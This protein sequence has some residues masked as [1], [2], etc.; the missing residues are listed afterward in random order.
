MNDR[1]LDTINKNTQELIDLAISI[2]NYSEIGF[3]E[4]QS[5]KVLINYLEKEGFS[6]KTPLAE[7]ETA[8]LAKYG[9]GRP[10][11]AL[12]AEYDALP[13]IGHAC[14]HN[15]IGVM[16]A[17]AAVALVQ[18]NLFKQYPGTVSVVGC[19]AEECGNV[20][21]KMVKAGI[22]NEIDAALIFHPFC[23]TSSFDIT[24]AIRTFMIEFFGKSAH[25]AVA[26]H[27]GINALDAMV[28]FFCAL[29]LLRQQIP[30]KSRIHG[31]ITRGGESFNTIPEYTQAEIGIRTLDM[32]QMKTLTEKVE[33][34]VNS[35]AIATD[36]SYKFTLY[37]E[38]P[39]I[40]VNL[41]IAKQFEKN[42]KHIGEKMVMRTYE[43]GIGSSDVGSVTHAVPGISAL[44]NITGGND[45]VPHTLE[46]AEAANSEMGYQAMIR[47]IKALTLTCIDLYT[48]PIFLEEVISY[49]QKGVLYK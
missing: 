43:Q 6:I 45:I 42:F 41:P 10:H 18:S 38:M 16:S 2:Y 11:L 7:F 19:P 47:A 37:S 3:E 33:N 46:F 21:G 40:F 8:F 12:L 26:P 4:F 39:E 14:G 36:C 5:S 32:E 13:K 25:A 31:I 9:N 24:Y 49:F 15:M 28:S 1:I 29:G 48:D 35:A 17:G 23:Q 30:E 20:K 44:I 34:I 27:K 22:F